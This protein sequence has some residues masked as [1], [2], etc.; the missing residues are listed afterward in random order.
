MLALQENSKINHTGDLQC[1]YQ[2]LDKDVSFCKAFVILCY[3][4]RKVSPR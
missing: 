3:R 4:W 2:F 1:F